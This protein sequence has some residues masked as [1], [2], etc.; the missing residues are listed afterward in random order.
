QDEKHRTNFC[1]NI[2]SQ[3]L[4]RGRHSYIARVDLGI[5]AHQSFCNAENVGTRLFER[6]SVFQ[7]RYNSEIKTF[8]A[9]LNF[10]SSESYRDPQWSGMGQGF[11]VKG[12]LEGGRHHSNNGVGLRIRVD[13]GAQDVGFPAKFVPPQRVAENNYLGATGLIFLL[14]DGAAE[15]RR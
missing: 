14:G 8:G 10:V 12:K 4:D 1:D 2:A 5:F 15:H 7:P 13:A 9:R 6:D 3:R 11:T